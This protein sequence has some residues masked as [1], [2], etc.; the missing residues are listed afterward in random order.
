MKASTHAS[1]TRGPRS[2][3]E[4]CLHRDG[5][6][7]HPPE[8]PEGDD[9]PGEQA[10]GMQLPVLGSVLLLVEDA[11]M[12]EGQQEDERR[13]RAHAPLA[14]G[15]RRHPGSRGVEERD[16]REIDER[17]EALLEVPGEAEGEWRPGEGVMHALPQSSWRAMQ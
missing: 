16:Q 7:A 5:Q 17:R 15:E 3:G 1:N 6:Q 8:L 2:S 10:L 12:E 14:P 11:Q 13:S 9:A 4:Q